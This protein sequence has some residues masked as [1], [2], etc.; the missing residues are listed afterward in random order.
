[1][2]ISSALFAMAIL[3]PNKMTPVS[4][5]QAGQALSLAYQRVVGRKPSAKILLLLL[6]QWALE[7]GN[8]KSVHNF[9]FGNVKH[10]NAD[11]YYQEFEGGETV[12]G[13]DVRSVMQWAAYTN[14]NDGALAFIQILKKHTVWWTGLQTGDATKFVDALAVRPYAYFTAPPSSYLNGVL[15]LLP[16]YTPISKKYAL[17]VAG[18]IVQVLL[19]LAVGVVGVY[20]Y[21]EV[22]PKVLATYSDRQRRK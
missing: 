9:N 22:K 17:S 7:T 15:K 8:G 21:H 11:Q 6:A 12:D 2:G 16:Q 20:A 4:A 14:I 10:S 18:T 1:V 13:V 5:E 3:I 19:G